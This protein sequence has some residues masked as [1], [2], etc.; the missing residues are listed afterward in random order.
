MQH[1]TPRSAQPVSCTTDDL[2]G[3]N[4]FERDCRRRGELFARCFGQYAD[5][6]HR[7]TDALG[8]YETVLRDGPRWARSV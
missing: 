6:M 3:L 5:A 7:M 1:A 8:R 2:A 4:A